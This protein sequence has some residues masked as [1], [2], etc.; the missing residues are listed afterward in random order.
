MHNIICILILVILSSCVNAPIVLYDK[1]FEEAKDII[2]IK[3]KE[4]PYCIILLDSL[5][6]SSQHRI[7]IFQEL[8]ANSNVV[9]YVNIDENDNRWVEKLFRPTILPFACIFLNDRI[10]DLIPGDTKESI[11]YINMAMK[12][13]EMNPNYHFNQLYGE[14][15]A[16]L[17]RECNQLLTLKEGIDSGKDMQ[18]YILDTMAD[19]NNPYMLYLK[20]KNQ[21]QLNDIAE[22]K[23]TARLLL[24]LDSPDDAVLYN[25][26]IFY[27]N[28]L[29]DSAY[30]EATAPQL[31]FS[32]QIV[33]LNCKVGETRTILLHAKNNGSYPLKIFDVLTSCGCISKLESYAQMEIYPQ[34]TNTFAFKFNSNK[35]GLLENDIYIISNEYKK[36]ITHILIKSNVEN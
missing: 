25:E 7:G 26:E 10:I 4:T 15:K 36:P 29:I 17:I 2:K 35:A 18:Q 27:A 3:N 8:K 24:S 5:Q 23:E 19:I 1:S 31:N 13:K 22:A 28:H 20:L 21:E 32:S 30:N 6:Y 14:D 16:I 34:T 33:E 12:N 11:A 9:A